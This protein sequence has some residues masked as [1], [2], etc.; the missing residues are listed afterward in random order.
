M[1]VIYPFLI[2]SWGH[3][4]SVSAYL[5]LSPCHF[6]ALLLTRNRGSL[7]GVPLIKTKAIGHWCS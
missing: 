1:R 3:L 6:A 4:F 2:Y 7:S 5:D